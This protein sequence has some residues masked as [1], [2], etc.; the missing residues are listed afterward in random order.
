MSVE[1]NEGAIAH[2]ICKKCEEEVQVTER[3]RI[4]DIT[5][6][7]RGLDIEVLDLAQAVPSAPHGLRV[8]VEEK[9]DAQSNTEAH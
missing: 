9:L 5:P 1:I 7:V 8:F 2:D 4:L 6:C 3:H